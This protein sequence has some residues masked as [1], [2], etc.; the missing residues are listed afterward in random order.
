[1]HS[2]QYIF[3]PFSYFHLS[4]DVS[5]VFASPRVLLHN[6]RYLKRPRFDRR[7]DHPGILLGQQP[8]QLKLQRVALGW[9]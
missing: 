4:D 2:S 7:H 6:L 3:P 8:R 9:L 5:G 1:M